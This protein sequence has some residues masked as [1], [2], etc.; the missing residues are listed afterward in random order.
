M[1]CACTFWHLTTCQWAIHFSVVISV[2]QFIEM[3]PKNKNKKPPLLLTTDNILTGT[4]D[5]GHICGQKVHTNAFE[6][7]WMKP[8]LWH[9]KF[10]WSNPGHLNPSLTRE[11][12]QIKSKKCVF[13]TIFWATSKLTLQLFV[14]LGLGLSTTFHD[15]M[16]MGPSTLRWT[17]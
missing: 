1:T 3:S 5:P 13:S 17:L 15:I 12:Q 14:G 10:P 16:I 9:S 2:I 7:G 8:I 11:I 4:H 6:D